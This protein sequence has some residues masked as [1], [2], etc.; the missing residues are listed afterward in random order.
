M[1]TWTGPGLPTMQKDEEPQAQITKIWDF[2]FRL[3]E[4]LNYALNN[5][6][7]QNLTDAANA[8]IPDSQA[9]AEIEKRLAALETKTAEAQEETE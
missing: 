6:D 5:L 7:R 9:F 3:Q 4:A 2:L 1:A 8:G